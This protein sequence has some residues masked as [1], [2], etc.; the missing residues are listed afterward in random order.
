MP[1][2]IVFVGLELAGWG[3]APGWGANLPGGSEALRPY[4]RVQPQLSLAHFPVTTV[5]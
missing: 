1:R 2:K 4:R 5:T 3:R